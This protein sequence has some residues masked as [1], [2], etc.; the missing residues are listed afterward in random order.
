M[1]NRSQNTTEHNVPSQPSARFI[2]KMRTGCVALTGVWGSSVFANY[3]EAD[4]MGKDA[5]TLVGRIGEAAM[6][7]G[8]VIALVSQHLQH[9]NDGIGTQS[10]AGLGSPAPGAFEVVSTADQL[11]TED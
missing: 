4:A 11:P 9:R 5:S 1:R 10:V 6:I 3:L 7:G 8:A 2:S